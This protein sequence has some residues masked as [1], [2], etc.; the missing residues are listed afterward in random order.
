VKAPIEI[1]NVDF[2][3][4]LEDSCHSS[5]GQMVHC[6]EADFAAEGEE[7]RYLV[8]KKDICGHCHFSVK[9]QKVSWYLYKVPRNMSGLCPRRLALDGRDVFAPYFVGGKDV[10]NCDWAIF[11][12]I[13]LD[14]PLVVLHG[15]VTEVG[16]ESPCLLCAL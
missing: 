8:D 15:R 4:S 11:N 2:F 5:V 12:L 13:A 16:V 10:I 1:K 3:K 9:F 6:R 7:E 14:Y